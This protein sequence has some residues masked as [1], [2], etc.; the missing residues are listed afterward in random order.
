MTK[1]GQVEALG[2]RNGVPFYRENPSI[3][4]RGEI[5]ARGRSV[6]V[7]EGGKAMLVVNGT[8]EVLGRGSMAYMEQEEV[9]PTRFVKLYLEGVRQVAGLKK[10]GLSVFELV[11]NEVQATPGKDEVKLSAFTA[12]EQ[13]GLEDRTFRRGLREL[14]DKELI[15]ASP[16]EGTFFINIKYLFN[17][18]RL[19]FVKSFYKAGTKKNENQGTLDWE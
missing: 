2:E 4:H 12:K 7:A 10:A 14:L 5:Q 9:D 18:N 8:G 17:G 3:P 16:Y 6:K 15:F 19:H 13:G 1:L 11:Y